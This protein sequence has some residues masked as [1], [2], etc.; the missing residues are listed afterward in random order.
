MGK[1]IQR[2]NL[3]P[4]QYHRANKVMMV[5]LILLYITYVVVEIM[6]IEKNG[7]STGTIL[8][9]GL[10]VINIIINAILFKLKSKEKLCMVVYA[11]SFLF[12]IN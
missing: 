9:C 3:T 1:L 7:F 5:I 4:S 11:I 8:R 2:Q 6:N 10:Y 12:V